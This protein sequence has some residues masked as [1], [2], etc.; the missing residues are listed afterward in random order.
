[1]VDYKDIGSRIRAIRMERGVSQAQLAEAVGV[2]VTHISHVETG[3]SIPS[4][5]TFLD[6]VNALD[7][8]AD[9]LLCLEVEKAKPLYE[10]WL[11]GELS[12]CTIQERK[13]ITDMVMS[14]KGSLRRLKFG[15]EK[16]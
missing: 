14:L 9:E 11:G 16:Q 3:S 6:I 5:P 12:D 13:L 2:G 4:L 10:N 1:M 8:S 15:D 7:C